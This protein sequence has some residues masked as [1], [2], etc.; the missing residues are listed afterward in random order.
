MVKW[1]HGGQGHTVISGQIWVLIL[2]LPSQPR[3]DSTRQHDRACFQKTERTSRESEGD[4][5]EKMEALESGGHDCES[6][7]LLFSESWV[8]LLQ[9]GTSV[10]PLS[11]VMSIKTWTLSLGGSVG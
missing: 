2:D 5:G 9:Y 4:T 10:L 3:A 1:P 6:Q 11:V 8:P 7:T